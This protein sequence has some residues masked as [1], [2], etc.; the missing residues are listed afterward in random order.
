M[1]NKLFYLAAIILSAFLFTS[2][3]SRK[4]GCPN[5]TGM[6]VESKATKMAA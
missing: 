3:A 6:K 5:S 4:Y 1:K 2:C